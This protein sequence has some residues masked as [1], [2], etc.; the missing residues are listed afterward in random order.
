MA[1]QYRTTVSIVFWSADPESAEGVVDALK[2][3]VPTED[4]D[5][6]LTTIEYRAEGRPE[7][8]PEPDAPVGAA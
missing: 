2:G 1:D 8:L 3:V 4:A 7:P 6:T 5:A